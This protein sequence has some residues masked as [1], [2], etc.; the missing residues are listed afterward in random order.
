MI[1]NTNQPPLEHDNLISLNEIWREN[2]QLAT[3]SPMSV[4]ATTITEEQLRRQHLEKIVQQLLSR[5]L[6]YQQRLSVAIEVDKTKDSVLKN[7]QLQNTRFVVAYFFTDNFDLR[8]EI[9]CI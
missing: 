2:N 7:L 3:I 1:L 4:P 8:L 6:E 5:Q 9:F